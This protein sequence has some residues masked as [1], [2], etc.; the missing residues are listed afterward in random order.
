M[1]IYLLTGPVDVVHLSALYNS[2]SMSSIS[3]FSTKEMYY[4]HFTSIIQHVLTKLI[5]VYKGLLTASITETA[6][7]KT[8]IAETIITSTMGSVTDAAVA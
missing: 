8:A 4:M 2:P 3:I 1:V 6:I 5:Y 7:A